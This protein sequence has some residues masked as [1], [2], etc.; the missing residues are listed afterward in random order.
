[1]EFH[2]RQRTKDLMGLW[3]VGCL[4]ENKVGVHGMMNVKTVST[5]TVGGRETRK[6]RR[7]KDVDNSSSCF[8]N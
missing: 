7:R 1:M 5:S 3:I 8:I 2:A 6:K 4:K